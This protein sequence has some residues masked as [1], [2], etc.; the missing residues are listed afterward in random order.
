MI[1]VS[2]EWLFSLEFKLVFVRWSTT[3]QGLRAPTPQVPKPSGELDNLADVALC[4]LGNMVTLVDETC[5]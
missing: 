5:H 4:M 2:N 3:T 1:I